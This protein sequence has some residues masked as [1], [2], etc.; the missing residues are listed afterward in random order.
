MM[1]WM[2]CVGRGVDRCSLQ[3]GE[4]NKRKK[5]ILQVKSTDMLYKK[6]ENTNEITV[7]SLHSQS[8][9]Q[10]KR[11]SQRVYTVY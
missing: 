2:A 3:V 10:Q 9:T 8:R 6:H 1:I 4:K 11:Y 7:H 5:Y